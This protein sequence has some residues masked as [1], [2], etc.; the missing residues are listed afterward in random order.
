VFAVPPAAAE[1]GKATFTDEATVPILDKAKDSSSSPSF[2]DIPTA[3]LVTETN[4]NSITDTISSETWDTSSSGANTYKARCTNETLTA[5]II[6]VESNENSVAGSK[7]VHQQS[8]VDL[9]MRSF[10]NAAPEA[11]ASS[12]GIVLPNI[13]GSVEAASTDLET[14]MTRTAVPGNPVPVLDVRKGEIDCGCP[15]TCTAGALNKQ[16]NGITCVGRINYFISKY[17]LGEAE[18]CFAGARAN[19]PCG[20]GVPS[21]GM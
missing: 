1:N 7:P 12:A 20:L 9:M 4:R 14:D 6:D 13:E 2:I 15:R 17:K 8:A 3:T 18:A 5:D 16:R 19:E 21:S 10:E 11:N